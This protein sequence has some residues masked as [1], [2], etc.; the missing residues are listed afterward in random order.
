M[1]DNSSIERMKKLIEEKKNINSN[2]QNFVGDS[3]K[4]KIQGKRKAFKTHK[5]GGLFDK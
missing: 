4:G 3:H 1:I 5:Q 2:K